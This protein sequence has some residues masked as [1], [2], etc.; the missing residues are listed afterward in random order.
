MKKASAMICKVK[1]FDV[2]HHSQRERIMVKLEKNGYVYLQS[3][4]DHSLEKSLHDEI[5]DFIRNSTKE[6]K[7]FNHSPNAEYLPLPM[8]NTCDL[9]QS[10]D[11][12]VPFFSSITKSSICGIY[13]Y[14]EFSVPY[15]FRC[16]YV[17]VMLATVCSTFSY[18]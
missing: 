2:S 7:L 15:I 14:H 3:T 18:E 13:P 8:V 5:T 11:V 1:F 9:E 17:V 16:K 12:Q 6:L 4:L 10:F